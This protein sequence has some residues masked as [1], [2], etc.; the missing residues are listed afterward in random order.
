MR[1]RRSKEEAAADL[2]EPADPA[3]EPADPAAQSDGR[4]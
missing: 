3:A 2:A 4:A 1:R